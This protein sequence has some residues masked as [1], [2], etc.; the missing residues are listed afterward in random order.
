MKDH[1]SRENF[2]E[3][4]L[5]MCS[6]DDRTAFT[7]HLNACEPC[8]R[9]ME[10][11]QEILKYLD[12]LPVPEC[13]EK[14]W[15][16]VVKNAAGQSAPEDL[17]LQKAKKAGL[18]FA[19]KWMWRFAV[20]I[21]VFSFGYFAGMSHKAA[22]IPGGEISRPIESE[23]QPVPIPGKSSFEETPADQYFLIQ[24]L[25]PSDEDATFFQT[26]RFDYISKPTIKENDATTG[27]TINNAI[28][29]AI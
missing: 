17:A 3:L 4:V 24:S 13:S 27:E 15:D 21:L 25:V 2:Y 20:L 7:S 9:K 11:T 22:G 28:F 18:S 19:V 14:R 29:E 23:S 5:D 16:E 6:E 12:T 8:K 26:L 10:E 1:L